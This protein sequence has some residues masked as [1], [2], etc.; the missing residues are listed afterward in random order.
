M[1]SGWASREEAGGDGRLASAFPALLGVLATVLILQLVE[2]RASPAGFVYRMFRPAGDFLEWSIPAAILLLFSWTVFDLL[3][4]LRRIAVEK[5]RLRKDAVAN[6][7]MVIATR[8]V[9][10]ASRS[11][12]ALPRPERRRL[13]VARLT[14]LVDLLRQTR[15]AGRSHEAFR[16]QAQIAAD[17]AAGGYA[18]VRVF[19]WAMPIL[20]FIGTVMGMG[21]AVGDFSG[22]LTGDIEDVELVKSELSKI[23][24]GLAFAFDTTLLGLV[25][26]LAAMLGT[27]LV[28]KSEE[29]LQTALEQ[30]GLGVIA[31][32]REEQGP[33][34][35]PA[36][37][38]E[39][40]ER[41]ETGL[42]ALAERFSALASRLQELHGATAALAE[43]V[44]L[45]AGS[46][47]SLDERVRAG[48]AAVEQLGAAVEAGG[49]RFVE[50][51]GGLSRRVAE[52]AENQRSTADVVPLVARLAEQVARIEQIHVRSIQLLDQLTGPL[53]LRIV[54]SIPPH[55]TGQGS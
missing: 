55:A 54:P 41:I 9:A 49:R 39:D 6:L 11:L 22:F 15:D 36:L 26:S 43:R 21:L 13:V 50:A 20:G 38:A 19:I 46:E 25:A 44:G 2:M 27:S 24:A 23:S 5:A 34:A 12:R 18:L 29:S 28:Q 32:F 45:V 3:G 42:N 31:N 47:Q 17:T 53:E 35:A 33:R 37:A 10:E 48:A 4:K 30:L 40:V 51:V 16:H 1:T 52:L 8:G 14:A 7:P